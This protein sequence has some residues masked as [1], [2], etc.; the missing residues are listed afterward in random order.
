MVAQQLEDEDRQVLV[1][2]D[3]A[4]LQLSTS[5]R[6]LLAKTDEMLNA[7]QQLEL[8]LA[9]ARSSVAAQEQIVASVLER[10]S[11]TAPDPDLAAKNT[12]DGAERTAKM[13]GKNTTKT[14]T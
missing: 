10:F 1:E 8:S 4:V 7:K 5:N 11:A 2:Q 13:D 9:T 14:R 6:E 3:A 12:A